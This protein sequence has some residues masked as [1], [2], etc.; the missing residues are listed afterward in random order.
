MSLTA[1]ETIQVEFGMA[2]R[3]TLHVPA[4]PAVMHSP[5]ASLDPFQ[6][7]RTV[8]P[9]R[10]LCLTSCAV[11]PTVTDQLSP[12]LTATASSVP[13]WTLR[14]FSVLAIAR[15]AVDEC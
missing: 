4:P 6:K 14:G 3:T 11:I 2:E 9:L 10:G 7:P 12:L 1:N 13:T 15:A 5:T 8:T